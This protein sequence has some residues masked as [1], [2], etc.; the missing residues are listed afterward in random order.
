MCV[1][2]DNLTLLTLLI[3]FHLT[4][5]NPPGG[6]GGP[7]FTRIITT[8]YGKLQ[9]VIKKINENG[10]S[11]HLKPIEM[12]LGVPYATSPTGANRFS[13]TRTPEPWD[14]I[15]FVNRV[16][17]V[18]PQRLPDIADET[19]A[20]GR[21]PRGRYEH[22]KRLLPHLRNQSEDCLYLNIYTPLQGKNFARVPYWFICLRETPL[23]NDK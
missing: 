19:E 17:P 15:K 10:I 9:G 4:V 14:G 6:I 7:S 18:C 3:L 12:Y 2:V 21:M 8:R 20:L 11:K 23:F 22:L 16:S 1:F 13:P 5:S